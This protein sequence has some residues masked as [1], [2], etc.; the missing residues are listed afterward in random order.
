MEEEKQGNDVMII[1]DEKLNTITVIVNG[2]T[3]LLLSEI[4]KLSVHHLSNERTIND[5]AP[6]HEIEGQQNIDAF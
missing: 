3:R 6:Q 4:R 1:T 5:I 2:R